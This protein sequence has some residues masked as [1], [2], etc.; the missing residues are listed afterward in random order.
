MG[1]TRAQAEQALEQVKEQYCGYLEIDPGPRLEEN[2][3]YDVWSGGRVISTIEAPYAIVWEEG[4][5]Y[6]WAYRAAQGGRDVE[7]TAELRSIPGYED[8][9]VDTPAATAWPSEVRAEPITTWI[10]GLWAE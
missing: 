7:L 10:L 3:F 9:V 5:P 2:F 6:E 4:G 8:A 1:I